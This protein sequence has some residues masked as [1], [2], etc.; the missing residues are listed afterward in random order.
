[1]QKTHWKEF[2]DIITKIHRQTA[3]DA[4]VTHNQKII[5]KSGVRRQIDVSM[6]QKGGIYKF[7]FVIECKWYNRR[8]SIEKV[9]AF[10]TKLEDVGASTGIMISNNGFSKGAICA[11]E[12][13]SITLLSYKQAEEMDWQKIVNSEAW[14]KPI[15]FHS[16]NEHVF[17]ILK[18]GKKIEMPPNK[19]LL[20]PNRNTQVNR[21]DLI[22]ELKNIVFSTDPK[23]GD[24]ELEIGYAEPVYYQDHDESYLIDTVILTGHLRALEYTVN[25]IFGNGHLLFEEPTQQQVYTEVTSEPFELDKILRQPNR[26]ISQEEYDSMKNDKNIRKIG[27]L[28]KSVKFMKVVLTKRDEKLIAR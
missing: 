11:A 2:E 4:V 6:I 13:Y 7:F 20:C 12:R 19:S 26:E 28:D 22:T 18:D 23:L 10:N 25:L 8:V 5:G 21:S 3:S 17:L 16:S 9:E 24:Y 27:R 15:F 1:M 14:I